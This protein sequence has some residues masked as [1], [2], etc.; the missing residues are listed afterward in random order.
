MRPQYTQTPQQQQRHTRGS[1]CWSLWAFTTSKKP[2]FQ[3][4]GRKIASLKEPPKRLQ[5]QN[6]GHN[7]QGGSETSPK[8]DL[9]SLQMVPTK[10]DRSQEFDWAQ[11]L[12]PEASLFQDLPHKPPGPKRRTH[13]SGGPETGRLVRLHRPRHFDLKPLRLSPVCP[14]VQTCHTTRGP[15]KWPAGANNGM[16]ASF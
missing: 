8:S 2:V 4:L 6:S 13:A 12:C 9:W 10:K 14:T 15:Q 7:V 5:G 11:W 1:F 16:F 3:P